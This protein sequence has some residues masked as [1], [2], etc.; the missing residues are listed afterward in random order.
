[1]SE[2]E[3]LMRLNIGDEK[4]EATR[5]N[6]QLFRHIGKLACYNHI[7]LQTSVTDENRIGAYLFESSL[8]EGEMYD[9]VVEY[10]I[11][12]EYPIHDNL[13]E[14]MECDKTAFNQMVHQQANDLEESDTFPPEWIG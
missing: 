3:P 1:M 6:T 9:R 14:V 4:F 7:F 11:D 5:Q 12:N 2:E 10:M 8:K 13:Q